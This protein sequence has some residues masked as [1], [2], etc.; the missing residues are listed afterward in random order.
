MPPPTE[1]H[2]RARL[3]RVAAGVGLVIGLAAFY[4]VSATEHADRVNWLKARGDQAAYLAEAKHLHA[5]WHGL[6]S[7]RPL[8]RNR[9]PLYPAYLA[10]LYDTRLSDDE[11]FAAGKTWSIRLSLV[12]LGILYVVFR[13][14][15]PPLVAVNLLLTVA[16]GYFVF[17]AGYVQAELLFY[18]FFLLTFVA[19]CHAIEARTMGRALALGAIAGALAALAHLTKAG[20]LPFVAVLSIVMIGAGAV[21]R[22]R[23]AAAVA[24]MASFLGVLSPYLVNSK[25]VYGRYF[26]N[27]NSSFYVWYDS[28]PAASVGTYS[29]GDQVGWP[30][31]PRSQLPGPARYWR[32]HTV[33]Q[34]LA[35]LGRGFE[36][37]VRQAYQTF[38]FFKLTLLYILLSAALI[39]S[40]PR[41]VCRPGPRPCAA[42]GFPGPVCGGLSARH[43]LLPPD[44]RD[45]D[46]ALSSRPCRAAALRDRLVRDEDA[47]SRHALDG[48]RY[49]ADPGTR[50]VAGHRH[51]CPGHGL[52]VLAEIDGDVRRVLKEGSAAA[53]RKPNSVA[54]AACAA[55]A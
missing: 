25:R 33:R 2:V 5:N 26:H 47:A 52:Y 15:F 20:M 51:H 54:F 7:P 45:R 35:R 30:T 10:V 9:M 6:Q 37:M 27:V 44:F 28:W 34:I 40:S 41:P 3:F 53:G 12:L 29:Y 50:S 1:V 17:K 11:F 21:M 38:W 49:R 39:W 4:L 18:T 36:D 13:L 42:R 31:L 46:R 23:I 43:R 24:V 14:H 32:E 8:P 55:T 16:F 48:G 22:W 19:S